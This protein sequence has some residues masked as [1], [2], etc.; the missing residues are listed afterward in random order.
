MMDN[1]LTWRPFRQRLAACFTGRSGVQCCL[2]DA[3]LTEDQVAHPIGLTQSSFFPYGWCGLYGAIKHGRLDRQRMQQTLADFV[4]ATPLT[5]RWIVTALDV[6]PIP[7]PCSR[8]SEDRTLVHVANLPTGGKPVRP[9]WQMSLLVVLPPEPSS[10]MYPL[11]A[12][13]VPSTQ[14][15]FAVGAEQIRRWVQLL[16]QH[17]LVIGDRAYPNA[18]FL[19]MLAKVEVDLL[20]MRRDRVWY[21]PA[22]PP[23]GKR[24]APRKDGDRFQGSKPESVGHPDLQWQSEDGTLVVDA[25]THLHLKE[26]RE[27]E[28]TVIRLTRLHPTGGDARELWL[29]GRSPFAPP[30]EHV[31]DWYR[32]RFSIEHGSRFAKQSLHWTELRVRSPAQFEDWTDLIMLAMAQLVIARPLVPERRLPWES[33]TRSLS[34]QQ[35]RRG[36]VPIIAQVGSLELAPKRRG[37]SPGRASGFHPPPAPRFSVIRKLQQKAT[38]GRKSA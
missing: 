23:T 34:P 20:R 28:G 3:L 4:P 16:P 31:A 25:W 24:G 27:V 12:T 2:L 17:L 8:T 38:N 1:T 18:P 19:R 30:L 13:R 22:P 29:F 11:E 7:R 14:T 6:T 33:A 10:F 37:K 21:R 9:G 5:D 26:A 32:L 15:A 35:V 36:L